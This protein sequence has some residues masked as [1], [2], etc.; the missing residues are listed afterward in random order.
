MAFLLSV[1][2][3]LTS[4]LGLSYPLPAS[5]KEGFRLPAEVPV[6]SR[7]QT[8]EMRGRL[9]VLVKRSS[10]PAASSVLP[11]SQIYLMGNL[12]FQTLVSRTAFCNPSL[13]SLPVSKVTLPQLV[14]VR[15]HGRRT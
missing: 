15:V 3:P 5:H 7:S 1:S 2:V 9:L 8:V 10:L 11:P 12:D 14:N 4:S 13:S 6:C